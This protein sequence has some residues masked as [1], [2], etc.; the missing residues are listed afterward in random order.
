MTTSSI[1]E[2]PTRKLTAEQQK[3]CG[4]DPVE[5]RW[6]KAGAVCS[7]GGGALATVKG[8]VMQIKSVLHIVFIINKFS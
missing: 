4:P 2:I 1:T 8:S 3:T 7:C 5:R 6:G